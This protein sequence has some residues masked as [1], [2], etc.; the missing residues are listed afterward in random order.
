MPAAAN[1]GSA[2]IGCGRCP[3]ADGLRFDRADRCGGGD[4]RFG[5]PVNR[6]AAVCQAAADHAIAGAMA[7]DRTGRSGGRRWGAAALALALQLGVIAGLVIALAPPAVRQAILPGLA[8]FDV[9]LPPPPP[10]PAPPSTSAAAPDR[11]AAAAARATPAPVAAPP[12]RLVIVPLDVPPVPGAG[13]A[14][15]AG[16]ATAG[17][18]TG[19]GG[20][21]TGTGGGGGQ[22]LVQTGGTIDSARDFPAETRDK[23]IGTSVVIVFTVGTDGRAH[24]CRVR[25]PSGDPRSDAITCQLAE[26]RFRFRPATD[27]AGNPVPAPYGWRQTWHY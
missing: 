5:S 22:R 17:Q 23:R 7:R 26:R 3:D 4:A 2:T 1:G 8:A 16:A 11:A 27:A 21:G 15:A 24:D 9:R 14:S 6:L 25:D 12:P 20:S 18:G 10:P 19:A 13:T